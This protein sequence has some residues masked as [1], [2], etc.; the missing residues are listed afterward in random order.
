[1]M[2]LVVVVS[3]FYIRPTL[4]QSLF[5]FK[6]DGDFGDFGDFGVSFASTVAGRYTR[7]GG[8]RLSVRGETLLEFLVSRSLVTLVL[9]VR[10][11]Y[12]F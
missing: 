2:T 11:F 10:V 4:V 3:G 7:W 8:P 1:M 5:Y 9:L 12:L 6:G